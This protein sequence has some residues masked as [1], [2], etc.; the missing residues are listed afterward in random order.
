MP[1]ELTTKQRLFVEAYLKDPNGVQSAKAAGY[2]GNDAQLAVIA[3][4]NLKKLN[5]AEKVEER[6]EEAV[7]TANEILQDVKD[8]AKQAERDA[9]RLKAYEMLGKHLKLWTDKVETTG[10]D[11]GPIENSITVK[12]I[13]GTRNK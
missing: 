10:K 9:D 8:I 12:I 7:I 13:D 11:G 5:I 6:I 2:K 3:S 4:Q 1:T